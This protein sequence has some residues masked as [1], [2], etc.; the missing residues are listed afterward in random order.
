MIAGSQCAVAWHV[1]EGHDSLNTCFA[2]EAD[3]FSMSI[4]LRT[5]NATLPV[6]SA[7]GEVDDATNWVP[8]CAF[9]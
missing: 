3:G 9:L 6:D 2:T 8:A 7:T 4:M 5:V 1:D